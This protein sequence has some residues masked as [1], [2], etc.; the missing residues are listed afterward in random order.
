MSKPKRRRFEIR[1][2]RKKYLRRQKIRKKLV[3][4][5]SKI[6]SLLENL[7][8]AL[9]RMH[10]RNEP[11]TA[12]DVI[13]INSGI[14]RLDALFNDYAENVLKCEKI[15]GKEEAKWFRHGPKDNLASKQSAF[16]LWHGMLKQKFN[17]PKL[18]KI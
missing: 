16:Y 9:K 12:K 11:P 18:R 15:L 1:L 3:A 13:E 6:T 5:E 14:E 8:N 2:K 10:E 17:I 7:T 4:E